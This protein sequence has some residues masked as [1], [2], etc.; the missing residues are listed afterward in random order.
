MAKDSRTCS[1]FGTVSRL[2]I[3]QFRKKQCASDADN[4][5][6]LSTSNFKLK[7]F[8]YFNVP[9][10]E[11]V[12]FALSFPVSY[13]DMEN[14]V[15]E[16]DLKFGDA[17]VSMDPKKNKMGA[18]RLSSSKGNS[19]RAEKGERAK[20]NI[21]FHKELLTYSLEKRKVFLLT[22]SSYDNISPSRED[23]IAHLFPDGTQ[24]RPFK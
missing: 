13:T 19:K 5:N 14:M 15:E 16:Y 24:Q 23:N 20:N 18:W 12:Y 6:L 7:I 8:H 21:Y 2:K 17:L 3:S 9:P 1:I 22:I 11:T 4:S 10:S